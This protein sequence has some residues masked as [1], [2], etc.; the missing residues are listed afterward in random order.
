MVNK[1]KRT[2][3]NPLLQKTIKKR[4]DKNNPTEPKTIQKA[5]EPDVMVNSLKLCQL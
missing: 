3:Q 2:L 4:F 5:K 1:L